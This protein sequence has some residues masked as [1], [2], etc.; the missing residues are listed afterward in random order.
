MDLKISISARLFI[1]V[2]VV[3]SAVI[4]IFLVI[5]VLL[6]VGTRL[7]RPLGYCSREYRLNLC[8]II[9]VVIPSL[10]LVVCLVGKL[11]MLAKSTCVIC[12]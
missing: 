4:I 3:I 6:M 7:C 1:H 9:N 2:T 10:S 11:F 12:P 5:H 8:V